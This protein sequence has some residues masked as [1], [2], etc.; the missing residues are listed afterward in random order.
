MKQ[1]KFSLL[2]PFIISLII[3]F[4]SLRLGQDTNGD[5]WN[6]HWYNAWSYINDRLT[7]D[8]GPAGA[9][10][11]L[12]PYL[13]TIYYL[14]ITTLRAKAHALIFGF[15]QG[16][17]AYPIYYI[18]NN[19]IKNIYTSSLIT[20]ICVL[21]STFFLGELGQSMQDNSVSLLILTSLAI[22]YASVY[23][24]NSKLLFLAG[25]IIGI[26]TGLKLTSAIYLVSLGIITLLFKE[27]KIGKVIKVSIIYSVSSLVGILLSTGHWFY[28]LY[29]N[30]G[31]PVFPFYNNI[32]KSPFASID[33]YAT[34]HMYFFQEKGIESLFYPF[35][36]SEHTEKI[37][38]AAN[39]GTFVLY[40]PM[41]VFILAPI[42]LILKINKK[43]EYRKFLLL[44][45]FWFTSYFIWQKFFGVYRYAM[46]NDLIT[47][48]VIFLSVKEIISSLTEKT[49]IRKYIPITLTILLVS[50]NFNKGIPTWGRGNMTNPYFSG[51]IPKNLEQAKVI[52][53]F[54]NPSGWIIPI[55]NPKGH[56]IGLGD[57]LFNYGT[58]KYW[59]LYNNY[60]D[61]S[62]ST[63]KYAVF[64]RAQ[65]IDFQKAN[66]KL[67]RYNLIIDNNNCLNFEVKMSSFIGHEIYCPVIDKK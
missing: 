18:V 20:A 50:L 4:I 37:A 9:H 11:Y 35:F 14:S 19:H 67:S 8:I 60:T 53:T 12:N 41:L 62:H 15:L 49:I 56:V 42:A 51:D 34:R 24:D 25:L 38:S 47:P 16:L 28:K 44:V 7:Y 58:E 61:N 48:L 30:Y 31:N 63:D 29:I 23:K 5:V 59:G 39:A 33:P 52:F 55:I 3:A 6:Y 17:V 21:G 32:F 43:V 26:A 2:F 45:V 57:M 64:D 65:P 27:R 54:S 46:P 13:D 66:L 10:S 1:K 40:T 22:I 36:F